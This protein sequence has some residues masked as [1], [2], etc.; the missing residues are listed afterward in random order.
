MGKLEKYRKALE[1]IV[2]TC[3]HVCNDF[4][5][6]SHVG[7]SSSYRA[8]YIASKALEVEEESIWNIKGADL[9]CSA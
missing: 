2:N 1:E 6:C 9:K 5:L 7:C 3:G 4:E 8:W